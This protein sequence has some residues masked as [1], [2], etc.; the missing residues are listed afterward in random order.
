MKTMICFQSE[1]E[2]RTRNQSKDNVYTP[3]LMGLETGEAVVAVLPIRAVFITSRISLM[4]SLMIRKR[5][6]HKVYLPG[7]E[8]AR[9]LVPEAFWLHSARSHDK[10]NIKT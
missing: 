8:K 4:V 2:N 3:G 6:L 7:Q 10:T 9:S 5:T 1:T